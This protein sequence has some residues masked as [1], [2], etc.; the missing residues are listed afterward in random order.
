MVLVNERILHLRPSSLTCY[1]PRA[2]GKSARLLPLPSRARRCTYQRRMSFLR[3]L[4]LKKGKGQGR[5]ARAGTGSGTAEAVPGSSPDALLL[6][7]AAAPPRAEN[8]RGSRGIS[9]GRGKSRPRQPSMAKEKEAE[10]KTEKYATTCL[11]YIVS[12]RACNPR[13]PRCVPALVPRDVCRSSCWPSCRPSCPACAC[14][15][16]FRVCPPSC[17][18]CCL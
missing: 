15:L 9:F 18:A 3:K 17:P 1:Y 13:A 6:T 2:R 10:K 14:C 8:R 12:Y 5:A 11:R 7:P 4:S 16:S